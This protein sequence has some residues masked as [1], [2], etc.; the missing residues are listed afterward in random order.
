MRPMPSITL[1]TTVLLAAMVAPSRAQIIYIDIDRLPP[2]IRIEPPPRPPFPRTV[3]RL[4]LKAYRAEVRVTDGLAQTTVRQTFHN[5]FPQD[6]EGRYVFPI[7][8][9]AAVQDFRLEMNGQMVKGEVL[10][11]NKAREIYEGIVRQ[12]RDPGLLEYL[13]YGL[14]QA[15]I[16]PIP[17]KND[18]DVALT[19]TEVLEKQGESL[20]AFSQPLAACRISG[21]SSAAAVITIDI[22][23]QTPLK[24]VYSP[25]HNVDVHKKSDHDAKVSYEGMSDKDFKLY[26]SLSKKEFGLALLANR[27]PGEDGYFAMMI[28]PEMAASTLEVQPK[29]IVFVVDTSGSM[30]GEKID[31]VKASLKYCLRALGAGDRFA[32]I[33]F[34]TEARP[35]SERLVAV[36]PE[37]IAR[38]LSFVDSIEAAGGTNIHDAL[39]AALRANE[40]DAS[41]PFQIL[42]LTDGLPT[43]AVTDPKVIL[44]DFRSA[45]KSNVRL[46]ALGV[47]HDV[48]TFLL[49]K[50]CEENHGSRDYVVPGED[51]EVKVSGLFARI[52]KPALVDARIAV[53]NIEIYDLQPHDLGDIFR[54]TDLIVL[55]RYRGEGHVAIRLTGQ[56]AGQEKTWTYEAT[57]PGSEPGNDFLARLWA[58]R[59]VGY[60]IDQIRLHG[61]NPELVD[62]IVR[63]GKTY[64]IVTPYT[65]NLVIEENELATLSRSG[66]AGLHFGRMAL[67]VR[68]LEERDREQL[69]GLGYVSEGDKAAGGAVAVDAS[70][71]ANELSGA[72][73]APPA[74]GGGGVAGRARGARPGEP[75]KQVVSPGREGTPP[76]MREID[77]QIFY[78]I[79]ETWTDHRFLTAEKELPAVK[80]TAFSDEYFKLLDEKPALRKFF[81]LGQKLLVVF[82]GTVYQVE[83]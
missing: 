59:K 74:T 48:N 80:V 1:A 25:T 28:S 10:D 9:A 68:R 13:G 54:G 47:G 18:I 40:N 76:N 15:S 42:F 43:V 56:Q 32:L 69:K 58:T 29:D 4:E 45:N 41:R 37:Q 3:D 46:L 81:A 70:R 7:P 51:L 66:S 33:P 64:G 36:D 73:V 82:E 19:Y 21:P 5:P 79:G 53:D 39:M 6:I 71:A 11:R 24:M 50:L 27:R 2:P 12:R 20:Y 14:I 55:G 31:Q 44:N 75:G 22:H 38:A 49:D 77:G 23:T 72:T 57:F 8:P 62:A 35:F 65:S 78:L 63:L 16:F 67:A 61:S 34:S 52:A 83:E 17:A 60:L 30:Q 26:Y